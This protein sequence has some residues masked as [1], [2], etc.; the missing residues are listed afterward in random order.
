MK[1]LIIAQV[2]GKKEE[3]R[4]RL[5]VG[6]DALVYK[7]KETPWELRDGT[8]GVTKKLLLDQNDA[9]GEFKVS[10]EIYGTIKPGTGYRFSASYDTEKGYFTIS[11]ATLLNA[12]AK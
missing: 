7:K 9:V 2:A 3:K 11:N 10:E 6:F 8:K 5:T 12:P 1:T 4:M